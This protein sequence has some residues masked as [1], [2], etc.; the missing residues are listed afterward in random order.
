MPAFHRGCGG[1]ETVAG[2]EH[3]PGLGHNRLTNSTRKEFAQ[4]FST[5]CGRRSAPGCGRTCSG[6]T[7]RPGE[8]PAP[9]PAHR[10][11]V[12]VPVAPDQVDLVAGQVANP[13][14]LVNTSRSM[15]VPERGA[16]MITT[17]RSVLISSPRWTPRAWATSSSRRGQREA[18]AQRQTA[19]PTLGCLTGHGR[20]FRP[21]AQPRDQSPDGLAVIV[22]GQMPADPV[23]LDEAGQ[24]AVRLHRDQDGQSGTEVGGGLARVGKL[25]TSGVRLTR[26]RSDVASRARTA[27]GAVVQK[28]D[29]PAHLCGSLGHQRLEICLGRA[30]PH[31]HELEGVELRLRSEDGTVITSR[32]WNRPTL[33]VNTRAHPRRVRGSGDATAPAVSK[34]GS[35]KLVRTTVSESSA[36]SRA[37][38]A[39]RMSSDSTT[40][41]AALR[42]VVSSRRWSSP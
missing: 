34:S 32:A 36:G 13:G 42:Q 12:A 38:T 3:D 37:I 41:A 33:P 31:E 30:L 19:P 6:C 2:D 7:H 8:S 35:S 40:M 5:P 20:E 23:L 18:A 26:P 16:P 39:S 24:R 14:R 11:V 9:V 4:V 25:I 29:P 10:R 17:S 21:A 15:L 22:H 28:P 1:V 27:A